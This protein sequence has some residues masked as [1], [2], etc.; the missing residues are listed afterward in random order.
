M[1]VDGGIL[2]VVGVGRHFLWV[3]GGRW[4]YILGGWR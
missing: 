4:R 1:E 3:S 2:L